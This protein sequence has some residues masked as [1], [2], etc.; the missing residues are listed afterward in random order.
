MEA[1][2]TDDDMSDNTY[3]EQERA[4]FSAPRITWAVQRLILA[5]L[6][7]F[8]AQLLVGPFQYL[9]MPGEDFSRE[10]PGG[11][12]NVWFGFQP[13]LLLRY[14]LAWKPFTYMFL[15]S[16]FLHL[17]FNMLWLYFFGPEVER[18]LGTMQFYRFFIFCGA[19]G[20]LLTLLPYLLKGQNVS[21]IGA[22]G[23]V[24]GV[25]VAFAMIDPHRQFY[26]IPFPWPITAR[27]L[28]FLV[29]L[30]NL[31]T[32]LDQS[33]TSV[34]THFGG[35][36]AGFLYMRFAPLLRQRWT[37]GGVVTPFPRA[38]RASQPQSKVGEAVDNIFKFK[39][40]DRR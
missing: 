30:L 17:G 23:A 29:V 27:G 32:S 3:F 9:L 5:N 6:A 10:F 24:M 38:R 40:Q 25:L 31:V 8:A 15:H 11:M 21:V 26:I 1:A 33:N 35:M 2:G 22:S 19:T 7:V 39:D 36:I 4:R 34:A 28:V 37:G 14:G 16:G 20:V 18:R 13:D 12:L